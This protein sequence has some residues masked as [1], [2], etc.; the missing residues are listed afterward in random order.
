MTDWHDT[1]A[2]FGD[3]DAVLRTVV[4]VLHVVLRGAAVCHGAGYSFDDEYNMSFLNL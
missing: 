2:V 3:V 4:G 1:I